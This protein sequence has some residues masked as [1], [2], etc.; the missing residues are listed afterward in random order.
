M[1]EKYRNF[2]AVLKYAL[3]FTEFYWRNDEDRFGDASGC[4]DSFLNSLG[5][6]SR[7]ILNKSPIN[8][9]S[10]VFFHLYRAENAIGDRS[11]EEHLKKHRN[12]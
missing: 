2:L 1:K 10:P 8:I 7:L 5:E 9:I 11:A 3:P 6:S 4:F 12:Q